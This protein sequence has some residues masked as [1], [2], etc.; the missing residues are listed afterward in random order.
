MP[1]QFARASLP[2]SQSAAALAYLLLFATGQRREE[3][4]GLDLA[5]LDRASAT[6]T[7]PGER[8]KNGEANIVPL[9]RHAMAVLDALTERIARRGSQA[10][11]DPENASVAPWQLHDARRTLATAM[12]RLGVRFEATEAVLN[13]VAGASRSGVGGSISGIAGKMKNGPRWTHGP[14][15]ATACSIRRLRQ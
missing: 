4:A 12:Q 1:T 14:I 5:E 8:S 6:W 9:N 13:H 10:G 15:I 11:E 2:Q 7:L 3:V